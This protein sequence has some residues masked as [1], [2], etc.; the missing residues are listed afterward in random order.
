[1][2]DLWWIVNSLIFS[3]G[4]IEVKLEVILDNVRVLQIRCYI[5]CYELYNILVITNLEVK[6]EVILDNVQVLQII[7]YRSGVTSY[8]IFG[9]Y[10]MG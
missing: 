2:F 10:K 7:C 5:R 4:S 8:I 3:V 1:M 6:L 9:H